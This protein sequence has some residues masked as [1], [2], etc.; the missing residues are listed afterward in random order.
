MPN[1]TFSSASTTNVFGPN[2]PSSVYPKD[3]VKDVAESLGIVNLRDNIAMALATDIEYRIR[4]IVQSASKY[5]KHSK[6]E[7][8]TT[9]DIDNALR[10]KNIE[11]CRMSLIAAPVRVFPAVHWR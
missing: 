3:S 7:Q 10:Q 5:M 4:D 1:N 6:R 8:L 11:V 2:I 9:A